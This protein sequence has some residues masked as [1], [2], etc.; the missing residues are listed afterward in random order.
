MLKKLVGELVGTYLSILEAHSSGNATAAQKLLEGLK[1]AVE[2]LRE[3]SGHIALDEAASRR[4]GVGLQRP[5]KVS[6][7][8]LLYSSA[9]LFLAGALAKKMG[10]AGSVSLCIEVLGALCEK[11][12]RVVRFASEGHTAV[13][14]LSRDEPIYSGV[15]ASASSKCA[16]LVQ[17]TPTLVEADWVPAE[18]KPLSL[19]EIFREALKESSATVHLALGEI[20][21]FKSRITAVHPGYDL[22]EGRYRDPVVAVVGNPLIIAES[23]PARIYEKGAG[24]HSD[25]GWGTLLPIVVEGYVCERA[26]ELASRI[27][28]TQ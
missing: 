20:E 15:K 23:D 5:L 19:T 27:E 3:L 1:R 6:K 13:L 17:L 26:R 25:L 7:I 21:V 16:V 12:K 9:D 10:K 22:L 8:G 14:G 24:I 4:I 28:K 2:S 11:G 18:Y